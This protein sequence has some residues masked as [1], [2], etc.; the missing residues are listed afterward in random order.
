[1]RS[2]R[3]IRYLATTALMIGI[4]T[5]TA[6]VVGAGA[7]G[8]SPYPGSDQQTHALFVQTDT[9]SGNTILSYA[10]NDGGSLTPAGSYATDGRGGQATGS[11]ADRTSRM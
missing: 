6:S 1:M 2:A 3:P 8:A 5:A 4:G 10:R 7:A 9:L 11:S